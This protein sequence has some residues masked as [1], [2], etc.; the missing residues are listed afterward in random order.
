MQGHASAECLEYKIIE[1]EDSVEA[2]CVGAPLTEAEQKAKKAE[3]DKERIKAE[4]ERAA[5]MREAARVTEQMKSKDTPRRAER[6]QSASEPRKEK[7]RRN[8]T[9]NTNEELTE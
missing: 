3:D 7:K 1:H 9:V 2:V 6:E 8:R 4:K 5:T